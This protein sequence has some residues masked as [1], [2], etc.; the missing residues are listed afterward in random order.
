MD[1]P[2]L[3]QGSSVMVMSSETSLDL[4]IYAVGR[5]GCFSSVVEGMAND[6]V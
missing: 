2:R 5:H 3:V 6:V 1:V 4:A